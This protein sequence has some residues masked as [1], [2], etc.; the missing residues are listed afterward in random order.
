MGGSQVSRPM[1]RVA[2]DILEMPLSNGM[3]EHHNRTLIDQL[4]KML[5]SH[6]GEWDMFMKQVAF[7]YNTSKHASTPPSY[8]MVLRHD[9]QPM[10]LCPLVFWTPRALDP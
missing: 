1:Q 2:A 4:A 7:A 9:V 8:L 3:V 10:C 5:L 6:G